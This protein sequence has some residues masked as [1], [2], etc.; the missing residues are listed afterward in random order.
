MCERQWVWLQ[1]SRD[2]LSFSWR[3]TGSDSRYRHHVS[4][5]NWAS[6]DVPMSI[7]L[8]QWDI[9]VDPWT[10]IGLVCLKPIGSFDHLIPLNDMQRCQYRFWVHSCLCEPVDLRLFEVFDF[11]ALQTPKAG[12]GLVHRHRT[13]FSRAPIGLASPQFADGTFYLPQLPDVIL[14]LPHIFS[15]AVANE[16]RS[17]VLPLRTSGSM[18]TLYKKRGDEYFGL[19]FFTEVFGQCRLEEPSHHVFAS[20][21]FSL[22]S[23]SELGH[24]LSELSCN[25]TSDAQRAELHKWISR[26]QST[27]DVSKLSISR[28][29][30]LPGL[31]LLKMMD[32]STDLRNTKEITATVQKAASL[33]AG[34]FGDDWV[35]G[36]VAQLELPKKFKSYEWRF[37]V[38]VAYM[39]CVRSLSASFD[40]VRFLQIDSSP[41][42]GRDYLN[43]TICMVKKLML[44]RLYALSIW[45]ETHPLDHTLVDMELLARHLAIQAEL[46]AELWIHRPPTVLV[47]MG[48]AGATAKLHAYS[49]SMR[50]EEWNDAMLSKA[51]SEFLCITPDFGVESFL[52]KALP[53]PASD[54]TPGWINKTG[55]V[56]HTPPAPEQSHDFSDVE[57]NDGGGMEGDFSDEEHVSDPYVLAFDR[58]LLNPGTAHITHN[59]TNALQSSMPNFKLRSR[60]MQKVCELCRMERHRPKLMRSCFNDAIGRLLQ[61]DFYGFTAHVHEERFATFAFAGPQLKTVEP[62]LRLRWKKDSFLRSSVALKRKTHHDEDEMQITEFVDVCNDAINDA[63]FWAWIVVADVVS[64]LVRHL[65]S[66]HSSCTCHWGTLVALNQD[67]SA[68]S[69]T[70]FAKKVRKLCEDCPCKG[71]RCWGI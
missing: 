62:A 67:T 5:S 26:L 45:L 36:M 33:V 2:Q 31:M 58:M 38:D 23:T 11:K 57:A 17:L 39:L 27:G 13:L 70:E 34:R 19:N 56:S 9:N 46:K 64:S 54:M 48:A 32:L 50:C 4:P 7:A 68:A 16:W 59:A 55:N 43:I 10:I 65:M 42:A 12:D 29:R 15:Q 18:D 44:P 52:N 25:V 60:Q 37:Y 51:I 8:R 63:M 14:T 41:Q 35:R 66:L 47:G 40:F 30:A 61:K 49:H 28:A 6:H 20:E 3:R 24:F 71:R 53:T 21:A 22:D 1:A 69:K